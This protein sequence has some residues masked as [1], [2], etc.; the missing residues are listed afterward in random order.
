MEKR[1]MTFR[2][3]VIA[4]FAVIIPLTSV[5]FAKYNGGSGSA[6]DP[7]LIAEANQMAAIG[8]NH[9]DWD[10]H[11][12]LTADIDL[13]AYTG[14]TFPLIGR[15]NASQ[16]KPFTGVFDG[17]DHT[18]SNFTYISETSTSPVGL[19]SYLAGEIKNLGLVNPYLN[20]NSTV[21]AL[22]GMT[23]G[24]PAYA[25][26]NDCYVEGGS[27]IGAEVAGG[28]VGRFDA[29]GEIRRCYSSATV[30]SSGDYVG[31]LIGYGK[32]PYI[33]NSCAAATVSGHS[34]VGGLLGGTWIGTS[35]ECFATG[36]VIGQQ[37]VGGLVGYAS[38]R[39]NSRYCYAAAIV[40]CA[41]V[42]YA[43]G[44]LGYHGSSVITSQE[45]ISS[46]WDSTLNPSLEGIGNRA[47]PNELR[48]R[49]TPELQNRTTYTDYGWDFIGFSD[50]GPDD[51][52]AILD[53]GDYPIFWWQLNEL[54]TLPFAGGNGEPNNPYLISDATQLNSIGHN[55]RL[56]T[57]HFLLTC[58]INL[59]DVNFYSVGDSV[60]PF[61]GVFDGNGYEIRR[62]TC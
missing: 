33:Y 58:D 42:N 8:L 24:S 56:M 35:Y 30:S 31:G 48:G 21:G 17:N 32:S 41:D 46:F 27:V 1:Q 20:V 4:L 19:F 18:I 7:F 34:G 25:Y 16:D 54:P 40:T 55:P 51:I 37:Y 45:F 15:Y 62:L 49:T 50:D 44:F 39:N 59:V 60:C 43:G 23:E 14:D 38:S 10:K 11:F 61:K 47:D 9:A 57:S 2:L 13:D 28:L 26:I 52:W 12:K 36:S 5:S 53:S 6:E 3:S 22:V 29:W